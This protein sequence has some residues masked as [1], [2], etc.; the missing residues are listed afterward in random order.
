M[1]G[2]VAYQAVRTQWRGMGAGLDYAACIP[3]LRGLL[4]EWRATGDPLVSEMTDMDLLEDVQTVEIA[5]LE[6]QQEQRAS[7]RGVQ[8]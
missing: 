5:I 4:E 3:V 6:V 8:P 1:P 2:V 7:Q